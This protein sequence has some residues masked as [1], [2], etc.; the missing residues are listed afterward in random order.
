[1]LARRRGT[2][3]R[4]FGLALRMVLAAVL[5]PV[6]VLGLFAAAIAAFPGRQVGFLVLALIAGTVST[7]IAY[8][9]QR[10]PE[11]PVLTE[12]DDPELFAV[13]TR[14]CALA[15]LPRPEVVVSGQRQ[16]NSWVVHQPGRTPRLYLTS[17]LR[18]LLTVDELSAVLSHELAHIANRDATVMTVVGSPGTV[19]RKARGGWAAAPLWLIGWL[20]VLGTNIL[21]RYRE[22]AAD[23]TAVQITGR[24][25]ALATALM[26]V[27][28]RLD[29]IPKTDLRA[30]AAM[31]AFNLVAVPQR[32]RW[33]QRSRLLSGIAATHPPLQARLDA[34]NELERVRHSRQS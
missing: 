9:K 23:A 17:E 5:T 29:H 32:R 12:A 24:P 16:P 14:L 11:G 19:M 21:S 7:V 6:I 13:L 22:L 30:A 4:R 28:D 26:K 31:N 20:S 18:E 1:M 33:W 8:R 27:S 2:G 34:L 10:P 15:D 25:S 3:G